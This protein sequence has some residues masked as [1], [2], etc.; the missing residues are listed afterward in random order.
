[1]NM[2]QHDIHSEI[3]ENLTSS[4]GRDIASLFLDNNKMV[5]GAGLQRRSVSYEP[6][7]YF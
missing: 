3:H 4:R 7:V 5:S 2:V 1:M 6:A